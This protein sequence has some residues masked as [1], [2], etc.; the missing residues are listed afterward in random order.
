MRR[1]MA[2]SGSANGTSNV[3]QRVADRS[4]SSAPSIGDASSERHAS[5]HH[6]RQFKRFQRRIVRPL[7]TS[8]RSR[9]CD[10]LTWIKPASRENA[11]Q[12]NPRIAHMF[13]F[14]GPPRQQMKFDRGQRGQPDVRRTRHQPAADGRFVQAGN[15]ES[16]LQRQLQPRHARRGMRDQI[17]HL[18]FIEQLDDETGRFRAFGPRAGAR[19]VTAGRC[20]EWDLRRM[21]V[22]PPLFPVFP[23]PRCF[24]D[25]P[26]TWAITAWDWCSACLGST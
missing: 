16:G 23:R 25:R 9:E 11:R 12:G 18:V 21:R 8:M 3:R 1:R 2:A 20:W 4:N 6:R 26:I 17:R 13:A 19:R 7:S 22:F 24:C 10:C 14:A 5:V 15:A